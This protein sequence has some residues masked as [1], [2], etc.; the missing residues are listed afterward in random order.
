MKS[1]LYRHLHGEKLGRF[2]V[3]MMRQAG[4]YLPK[5][6]EIRKKHS[7]WEMATNPKLI[8]E[9]SLLPLEVI[10]V[11]AIIFFADI[12][13]LPHGLGLPV[14]MKESI[15]PYLE[16][17]MRT[18]TEFDIFHQFS[19]GQHTAFLGEAL[20]SIRGQIDTKKALIGFAGAP[21]T[22]ACYLIEGKSS[23]NFE[24]ILPWMHRDPADLAAALESLGKATAKYLCYQ[25]QNHVEMVQLFDTWISW[26]P[27]WFFNDYYLPILQNIFK[28][29]EAEGAFTLYYAKH[30]QQVTE[31]LAKTGA[32]GFSVDS[33]WSLSEYEKAIGTQFSFQGNLEPTLLLGDE[34]M[35]RRKTREL[36]IEARKLKQPAILNLGHGILPGVPVANAKAFIDEARTMWF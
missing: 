35:V 2:P 4:R 29:A 19:P 5:Y 1:D 8:T 32:K 3:W 31:S 10:D 12:L 25:V 21:W 13:T 30:S 11:D 6:L 20:Q 7:F 28:E 22:V 36:V 33:L 34:A 27:K 15:G 26:M 16:S 14:Q 9:V 18:R 17:P 24:H 23:K